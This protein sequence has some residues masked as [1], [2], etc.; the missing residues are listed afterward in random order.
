MTCQ[1][2]DMQLPSHVPTPPG[3]VPPVLQPCRDLSLPTQNIRRANLTRRL[4]R[5]PKKSTSALAVLETAALCLRHKGVHQWRSTLSRRLPS[6]LNPPAKCFVATPA[7][8]QAVL[9]SPP[10][11]STLIARSA[12]PWNALVHITLPRLAPAAGPLSLQPLQVIPNPPISR[13]SILAWR[14]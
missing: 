13:P 1:V 12:L 8:R 4:L 7:P 14:I 5:C 10:T 3:I 9:T 2:C 11:T 6:Q